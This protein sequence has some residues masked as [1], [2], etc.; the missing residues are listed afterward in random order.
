MDLF[1]L[2]FG[3]RKAK[4]S[5]IMTDSRKKC[6][7]YQKAREH[8]VTG[9]H[10]IRPAE[11]GAKV[12]RQKSATIGGNRDEVPRIKRGRIQINGWIGK[13]GFNPHT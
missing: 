8:T 12:W 13:N 1:T 10:E 6:E 2:Y 7:N 9:F 11:P 4:M 5:P 3:R